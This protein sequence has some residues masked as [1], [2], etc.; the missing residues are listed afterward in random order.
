MQQFVTKHKLLPTARWFRLPQCK[1]PRCSE[2]RRFEP[3]ARPLQRTVSWKGPLVYNSS[4]K[5]GSKY[6]PVIP[7]GRCEPCNRLILSALKTSNVLSFPPHLFLTERWVLMIVCEG[8]KWGL[9][10]LTHTTV[11]IMEAI[12]L[13]AGHG[14]NYPTHKWRHF[15]LTC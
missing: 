4:V 14:L 9:Q 6:H 15:W 12:F 1:Y 5:R 11:Q 3:I 10:H 8:P 7:N 13:I 2:G